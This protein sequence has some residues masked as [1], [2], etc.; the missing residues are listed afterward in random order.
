MTFEVEF[1]DEFGA[2]WNDLAAAEQNADA[3]HVNA[4]SLFGPALGRPQVDTLKGSKLPNLK[5]LRVQQAGEP[6]RI[7]FAFNP[8]LTALLLI[9]GHKTGDAR[10]YEVNIP[11][12]EALY[13][14]HLLELERERKC[15]EGD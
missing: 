13:A 11:K 12:A 10:W 14:Q 4:L 3:K 15:P 2:W 7:L 1:T 5:E 9:G 8:L 6:I